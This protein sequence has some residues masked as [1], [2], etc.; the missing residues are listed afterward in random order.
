MGKGV[1]DGVPFVVLFWDG[2]RRDDGVVSGVFVFGVVS[3]LRELD[4][5]A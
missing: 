2:Y 5:S 1:R 4:E 3:M